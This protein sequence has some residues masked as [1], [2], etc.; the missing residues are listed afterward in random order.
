MPGRSR[1][2]SWWSQKHD[3]YTLLRKFRFSKASD[4]RDMVYALVRIA[5]DPDLE[6][7]L[8]PN[9]DKAERQVIQETISFL[10]HLDIESL[11]DVSDGYWNAMVDDQ[12]MT[13]FLKTIDS[14]YPAAMDQHLRVPRGNET[15]SFYVKKG[16]NIR[17]TN[18]MINLAESMRKRHKDNGDKIMPIGLIIRHH[19]NFAML[20]NAA[21]NWHS[22]PWLRYLLQQLPASVTITENV[23]EAATKNAYSSK[24]LDLLLRGRGK[25][26]PIT[27]RV[28]YSAACSMS[29][30]EN[31]QV[32]LRARR[33]QIRLTPKL[34]RMLSE[35]E[36]PQTQAAIELLKHKLKATDL[37][38]HLPSPNSDGCVGKIDIEQ[39]LD[40][41]RSEWEAFA[42]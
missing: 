6:E 20:K 15:T 41:F 31:F 19:A 13:G 11:P 26:A 14:L 39:E 12:S 36:S 30:K 10:C 7:V 29:V 23:M 3:L 33:D 40:E 8:I 21:M 35:N 25:E 18:E 17:I 1:D 34:L 37:A 4:P 22:I 42:V 27:D 32:I 24:V 28:L 9:Y 2:E 16:H 5:S 38:E